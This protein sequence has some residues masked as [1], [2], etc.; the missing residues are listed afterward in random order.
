[1]RL[2]PS[3]GIVVALVAF[4][5]SQPSDQ[6]TGGSWNRAIGFIDSGGIA[7]RPILAPR[8]VQ[9]GSVF[10]VTV[11]TF[12]STGCIRPDESQVQLT[13]SVVDITPY[14]S[15]WSNDPPCLPG[16]QAYPRS[17]E[18]RFDQVGSALIRLHGRGFDRTLTLERTLAVG[19]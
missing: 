9:A 17:L 3:L 10:R 18:L 2:S 15:V 19:P 5:C 12:G 7:T 11:S 13:G 14:D 4:G 1:M 6:G 8:S 16:W